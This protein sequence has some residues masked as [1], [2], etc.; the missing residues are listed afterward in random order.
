MPRKK[1]KKTIRSGTKTARKKTY[2][3]TRKSQSVRYHKL[4]KS[5]RKCGNKT[6]KSKIMKDAH[7]IYKNSKGKITLGDAMVRAHANCRK[8]ALRK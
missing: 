3:K 7:R 6:N 1:A 8:K 4:A 5:K 2:T